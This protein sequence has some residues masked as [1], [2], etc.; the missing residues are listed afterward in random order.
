M[1]HVYEGSMERIGEDWFITFPCFEGAYGGGQTVQ[2]ACDNAAEALRMC[3]AS[4]IDEGQPLPHPAF[5]DNPQTVFAVEVDDRYIQATSTVSATE[6]AEMLGVS[7]G[8]VSV[9]VKEGKLDTVLIDG[10]ARVTIASINDRIANPPAA[11]RPKEL[12]H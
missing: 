3:I 8:R 7:K 12:V 5:T 1:T 4:A 2:K 11:H 10:R 9:L 6:A